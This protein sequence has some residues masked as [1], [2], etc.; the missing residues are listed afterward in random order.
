MDWD[1]LFQRYVWNNQT[2][3]YMTAVGDLDLRKANNEIL[4]Y[5]LFHIVLFSVISL[6]SLRVGT[7]GASYGVA[8][9]AF[10][11]VCAAV[12]FLIMKNYT[13]AL[14]LSATPLA[15]LAYVL[16]YRIGGERA[17]IDTLIVTGMLLL[18]A[19]YS[20]RIVAVAKIYPELPE[21]GPDEPQF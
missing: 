1:K 7:E 9:Y 15:G 4:F 17:F 12:I 20:F 13:A 8:Y 19:R 18:A 14:F 16:I 6:A 3:P 21:A 5:C 10:A 11:V 2:M